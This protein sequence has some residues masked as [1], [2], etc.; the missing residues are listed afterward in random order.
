MT[1]P[2]AAKPIYT[3]G[4][5]DRS[6]EAFLGLLNEHGVTGLADVRSSP[7]SRHNPEF[8][9]HMLRDR[10]RE[11]GVAYVF[12]GAELGGRPASSWTYVDGQ[13]SY[14]RLRA[15]PSFASGIDRL[16]VG[17]ETL[18]LAIMCSEADPLKC[19]RSLAIA[20]A[21]EG[22]GIPVCHILGPGS[23]ESDEA[24]MNRLIMELRQSDLRLFESREEVISRARSIQAKR[25][26]FVDPRMR[27]PS[28]AS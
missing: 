1:V 16:A 17:M 8:A 19:H 24:A 23:I 15:T 28:T 6:F 18:T 12:L 9:Q 25:V 26:A 7:Y 13:V 21:L 27:S 10:L 2:V 3:I 4:H 20:P 14:D 5:S 11:A 22:E